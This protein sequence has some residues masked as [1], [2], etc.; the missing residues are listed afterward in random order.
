MMFKKE[1]NIRYYRYMWRKSLPVF[2]VGCFFVLF[3]FL[4]L[5]EKHNSSLLF[6]F[7]IFLAVAGA[8]QIV[9]GIRLFF[10]AY[11]VNKDGLIIRGLFKKR[12]IPYNTIA[13]FELFPDEHSEGLVLHLKDGE[14]LDIHYQLKGFYD[15]LKELGAFY[16]P[17]REHDIRKPRCMP[18]TEAG[19]L[20]LN[21]TSCLMERKVAFIVVFGML[22]FY[23]YFFVFRSIYSSLE[24]KSYRE[25][26][27]TVDGTVFAYEN[28]INFPSVKIRYTDR[29]GETAEFTHHGEYD[30]A[31]QN[32]IGSKLR[33]VYDPEGKHD[34]C[35]ESKIYPDDSMDILYISLPF[36]LLV[37]SLVCMEMA[38]KL[39]GNRRLY[40]FQL[41]I[42]SGKY[43]INCSG[44]G[45]LLTAVYQAAPDKFAGCPLAI[46]GKADYI[47]SYARTL[48]G[49]SIVFE[50]IT[51][52]SLVL[53]QE[54][55]I[56][57]LE[58]QAAHGS[59]LTYLVL[60]EA[61]ATDP[62]QWFI[63]TMDINGSVDGCSDDVKFFCAP[64]SFGPLSSGEFE[65]VLDK[66]LLQQLDWI[67]EEA[68]LEPVGSKEFKDIVGIKSYPESFVIA[69]SRDDRGLKVVYHNSNEVSA[70]F[71][72]LNNAGYDISK[73][74]VPL[75][76]SR[77]SWLSF[78]LML[79]LAPISVFYT[80]FTKRSF[81]VATLSECWRL[82]KLS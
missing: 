42:I 72:L 82:R 28:N 32:P 11:V 18:A 17:L 27:V 25:R 2:G 77:K 50:K 7:M 55:A 46:F 51:K 67:S 59:N 34:T 66:I 26:A 45:A 78:P 74:P 57:V 62:R 22:A 40:V 61:A 37:F 63:N 10:T 24:D 71:A 21:R 44:I 4:T 39:D 65:M 43:V 20:E 64:H 29:N 38:K 1:E 68:G 60:P 47:S 8:G 69:V 15:L 49:R 73:G 56:L 36:F 53:D 33:I 54:N 79:I 76:M 81:P 23:G 16:P 3:A 52:D 14:R 58:Q 5:S 9:M 35:L 80:F 48:K 41:N 12:L 31:G 6:Y 75:Y 30:F 70:T 13:D 19:R